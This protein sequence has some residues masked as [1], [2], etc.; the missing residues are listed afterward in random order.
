VA[1]SY[2]MIGKDFDML[3]NT[4]GP[5]DIWDYCAEKPS[6]ERFEVVFPLGVIGPDD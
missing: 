3:P 6:K 1:Y 2:Y 4:A 5:D